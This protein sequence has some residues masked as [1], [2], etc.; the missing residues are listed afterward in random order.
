MPGSLTVV[1]IMTSLP[2][3]AYGQI[4]S[5][6]VKVDDKNAPIAI[7]AEQIQGSITRDI[8]LVREV[9]LTR[10]ITTINADKATFHQIENEVDAAGNV[11]VTRLGDRYTGDVLKLNLDSSQG[12]LLNPTYKLEKNNGQG[13]AERI[14]FQSDT[15]A[16]VVNGTYSTCEGLKPDWYLK[17]DTLNLDTDRDIGTATKTIIY[18][19]GV[20]IL[21]MPSM[22]FSLSGRKSGWLPPVFELGSK[23]RQSFEMPYYFNIAP[24]RDLTLY[25]KFIPLR[26]LQLGAN[27][28][29]LGETYV[30]QTNLEVLLNDK[31]TQTNRYAIQSHHQQALAPGLAYS[32]NLNTAS[33]E[34]YPSDFSKSITASAERQLL[35]ELRIDYS[36][37]QHWTAS[38]RLQNY[39]VLQD[40]ASILNPALLLDRPYDRL[41]QLTFHHWLYDVHGVDW[42]FDSELT[43]FS[44]PDKVSG[45]RLVINPQVSYPIVGKSYFVTPKL[46]LHA[47][48]Y[49]LENPTAGQSSLST[50]VPTLS[51]DSGMF[52]EREAHFFGRQMTQTIEPRLFYVNTPYRNQSLN[53]NFDTAEAG[54]NFAQIF[55]ENRFAGSDR[56]SDANQL[57]AA[58]VSRYIEQSGEEHLRFAVGQR[59]YFKEQKVVLDTSAPKTDVSRSDW[60]LSTTGHLTSSLSIDTAMQYSESAHR[61][62]SANTGIEWHPAPK[63]VL[64]AE[65]RYLRNNVELVKQ[66]I[67]STQWPIGQRWYGMARVNYSLQD[68]KVVDSVVGL[69]YKADCW[70]MRFS[71]QHFVTTSQQSSTPIFLQLELN[72]LSKIGVGNN[73]LEGLSRS[74]RR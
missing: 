32:W 64:N 39:L 28:R 9:Q 19:K 25:P 48:N 4:S 23:G 35:R 27:G 74:I 51:V 1:V 22:S 70:V 72:G 43:R 15:E 37:A 20:P 8:D 44:H 14:D 38:A 33:D 62:Y 3:S 42:V 68:R 67:T 53:P 6:P 47:T 63:H 49:Q 30:G 46:S 52:L 40:P 69:E 21:G 54:F 65:Y 26:G 60:L 29:Y 12:F 61:V 5:N 17:A 36:S 2:L 55:S 18:F 34:A 31:K 16:S 7:C 45:S 13:K 57:T 56:I 50:V 59:F 11:R 41:P 73:P 10:G 58:L 71:A 24:N 66:L